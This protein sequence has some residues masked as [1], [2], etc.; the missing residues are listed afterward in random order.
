[1]LEYGIEHTY[2]TRAGHCVVQS[3]TIGAA[4]ELAGI[5]RYRLQGFATSNGEIAGH[6]FIYI[7]QYDLII[8]N[9]TILNNT[10]NISGT[11]ICP[12]EPLGGLKYIDFIEHD[13]KWAYLWRTF[14]SSLFY[15]TLSPNETIEILE[16]LRGIHNDDIQCRRWE[17]GRFIKIPLDEVKQQLI[18]EQERWQPHELPPYGIP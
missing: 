7:P 14:K 6:D 4:L 16:Y 3:A 5:D 12:C 1:M 8:S 10:L 2:R 11:V 13:G 9:G 15:G 18:E 17:G